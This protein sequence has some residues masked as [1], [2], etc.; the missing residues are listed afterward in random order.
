[1]D[2]ELTNFRKWLQDSGN[3]Y[4]TATNL[5]HWIRKFLAR[6]PNPKSE[7]LI[8]SEIILAFEADLEEKYR[9]TFRLAWRRFSAFSKTV[10][11]SILKLPDKVEFPDYR[12]RAP[13]PRLPI[14]D[15]IRLLIL[16][17]E[18]KPKQLQTLTWKHVRG[19]GMGDPEITDPKTGHLY[20][21]PKEKVVRL[22]DWAQPSDLD[23]PLIPS[24][25]KSRVPL[26]INRL[27]KATMTDPLLE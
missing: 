8:S 3:K 1:M 19:S 24:A 6:I 22:K 15:V 18:I 10:S 12:H 11:G 26:S 9:A 16:E 4:G 2:L 7:V 25:P 21:V 13:P 27:R 14:E 17:F 5:I 20:P 23:A